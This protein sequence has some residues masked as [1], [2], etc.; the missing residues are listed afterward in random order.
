MERIHPDEDVMR[1]YIVSVAQKS[2][3]IPVAG[4]PDSANQEK[5]L[6]GYGVSGEACTTAHHFECLAMTLFLP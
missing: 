3:Q 6:E 4:K 1:M 5:R 2:F